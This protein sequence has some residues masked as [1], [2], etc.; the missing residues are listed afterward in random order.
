MANNKIT[1][2]VNTARKRYLETGRTR[3]LEEIYGNLDYDVIPCC[4]LYKSEEEE[5]LR[6]LKQMKQD[7]DC[8][9]TLDL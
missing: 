4:S 9:L 8:Q 5:L 1:R 6:Q 2:Y 3:T 7:I